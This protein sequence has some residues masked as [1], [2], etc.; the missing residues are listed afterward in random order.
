MHIMLI[1]I[2]FWGKSLFGKFK[3]FYKHVASAPLPVF[4]VFMQGE[5]ALRTITWNTVV[6]F[7][8]PLVTV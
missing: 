4:T 8:V 2:F 6:K 7:S 3:L 1:S 5:G